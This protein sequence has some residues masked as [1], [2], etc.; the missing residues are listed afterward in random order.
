MWTVILVEDEV[1]VR[2]TFRELIKW[3]DLG[4][5]IIGEASNGKE[6]LA[7]MEQ[8]EP[9]LVISDI[10]MPMMNG[11]D[12]LQESRERGF[13]SLFVMLTCLNDFEHVQKAIELGAANYILKL[14]MNVP[15]LK[16]TLGKIEKELIHQHLKN[17]KKMEENLVSLWNQV[18]NYQVPL[19]LID[20]FSLLDRFYLQII[21]IHHGEEKLEDEAYL[22]SLFLHSRQQVLTYLVHDIGM[23][24]IFYWS[25]DDSKLALGHLQ[26]YIIWKSA[27]V[28]NSEIVLACKD[29]LQQINRHWTQSFSALTTT[30]ELEQSEK[31]AIEHE[32]MHG[33]VNLN[34][35]NL[36]QRVEQAACKRI[37][38]GMSMPVAKGLVI[39]LDSMVARLAGESDHRES[40]IRCNTQDELLDIF[41]QNI[42]AFWD[43]QAQDGYALYSNHPIVQMILQYIH[44]HYAEELSV[45]SLA[46]KVSI[47]ENYLSALFKKETGDSL[48][49]YIHTVRIEQAK[50]LLKETTMSIS[51]IAEQVGFLNDNYFI[52]IF[53]RI[54]ESTPKNFRKQIPCQK[55]IAVK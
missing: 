25:S 35:D 29:M 31:A 52:K 14:S 53:K 10:L 16:E 37:K 15:S 24:T 18:R 26:E 7:L 5:T 2:E 42:L 30:K 48:I 39:N 21:T 51:E 49:Q 44:D 47:D 36:E 34:R 33:F 9:D 27:V 55:T 13:T 46:V 12:L 40:Y 50:K 4:F 6:A 32:V 22:K 38:A 54:T 8:Q 23:T 11:V 28:R 20:T 19:S 45:R 1:F 41:K 17:N 43:K 3:E